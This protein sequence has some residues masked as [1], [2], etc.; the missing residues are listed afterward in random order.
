MNKKE[1]KRLEELQKDGHKELGHW[2]LDKL[3]VPDL[4]LLLM[5]D[6]TTRRLIRQILE[7]PADTET[8]GTEPAAPGN[9]H[10][11]EE[12]SDMGRK[13]DELKE[14]LK[15]EEKKVKTLTASLQKT[16]RELST[17][18]ND[19]TESKNKLSVTTQNL[20]TA[21]QSTLSLSAN[22]REVQAGLAMTQREYTQLQTQLTA[23]ERKLKA[24]VTHPL[25]TQLS[26]ELALLKA[27]LADDELS[28]QWHLNKDENP[29]RQLARLLANLADWDDG[30]CTLW[31]KLASRCKTD[32]RTA[33]PTEISMLQTALDLHNLRYQNRA[34]TLQSTD[35]GVPFHHEH[36]QRGTPKGNTV[37]AV[38][39]PGL[40]SAAG[41]LMK[42]PVV[43]LK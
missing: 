11:K 18:Q 6:E 13:K 1:S 41:N 10:E 16:E 21:E 8:P 31:E 40:N 28:A 30:V 19:L 35:L 17:T 4:Q 34:A 24:P 7:S 25:L 38:W 42:F 14:A 33:T 29:G 32:K 39:L 43:E 26:P 36:M 20:Q 37:A 23:A 9:D 5:A 27:L 3:T 15:A 12:S 2:S 22:L